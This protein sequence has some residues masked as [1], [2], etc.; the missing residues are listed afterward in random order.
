MSRPEPTFDEPRDGTERATKLVEERGLPEDNPFADVVR[1]LRDEGESWNDIYDTLFKVADIC[2]AAA[3]EETWD[4]VP[5]WRVAVVK[6]DAQAT[7]GERYEYYKR[8]AETAAKAEKMVERKTGHR[9][10]SE[11]T[12]QVSVSKVD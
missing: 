10:E 6:P 7:S 2:D 8:T 3:L 11:K 9:V 12:E 5:D 4:L 1:D